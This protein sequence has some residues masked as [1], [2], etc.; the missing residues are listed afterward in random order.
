V[1][2]IY[3]SCLISV[4][5]GKQPIGV[6][7]LLDNGR[8]YAL[9]I[10]NTQIEANQRTV[11][12]GRDGSFQSH[13]NCFN[14][15]FSKR[16]DSFS[17]RAKRWLLSIVRSSY[18]TRSIVRN[19]QSLLVESAP[20]YI[21]ESET[22]VEEFS[23]AFN[24]SG[25]IPIDSNA[26]SLRVVAESEDG[27]FIESASVKLAERPLKY[28]LL[29][30]F[31]RNTAQA[32]YRIMRDALFKSEYVY[33]QLINPER[34]GHLVGPTDIYLSEKAMGLHKE[35]RVRFFYSKYQ[36]VED[37]GLVDIH[38]RVANKFYV[39]SLNES[40]QVSEYSRRMHTILNGIRLLN[41]EL[42]LP[43]LH[44]HRDIYGVLD[45]TPPNIML[46]EEIIEQGDWMC[47]KVG[48]SNNCKVVLIHARDGDYVNSRYGLNP[49]YDSVRY[50]YR[51]MEIADLT[52]AVSQLISQGFKV[53][54][55]GSD[56]NNL[57]SDC[58]RF[59]NS[60]A[61]CPDDWF[62]LYLF[63]RSEFLVGNTSG[64]YVLAD[65]FRKPIIF[66][67]FAPLGHVYSWSQRHITIFKKMMDATTGALVPAS[68]L[69]KSSLGWEIHMDKIDS[70]RYVYLD[71]TPQEILAV[72]QEMILRLKGE[73]EE[74]SDDAVMQKRFWSQIPRGLYHGY[75][76]SRIGAH[77]LR[78]NSWLLS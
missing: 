41:G 36:F 71:N 16:S 8:V 5:N 57:L 66:C 6:Y 75:I 45:K 28:L 10:S 18:E 73:Y 78:S 11:R 32:L 70:R 49:N 26:F 74:S 21:E 43:R 72:T 77:Y 9:P 4:S 47:S 23:S 24:F 52:L 37:Q 1:D 3:L 19:S 13:E 53:I 35:K 12:D 51:N 40:Y 50:G 76:D 17:S 33:F 64:V 58:K 56:Q 38:N 62:D 30:Y 20:T 34:L 29:F 55:V 2:E 54:R 46:P 69:L 42:A 27:K 65:L 63:H 39:L 68:S 14:Y 22:G 48:I 7:A 61:L 59:Y 60:K 67:N 44:A 15:L 31:C 25:R